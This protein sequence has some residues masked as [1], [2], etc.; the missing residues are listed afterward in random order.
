ME[1]FITWTDPELLMPSHLLHLIFTVF[2]PSIYRIGQTRPVTIIRFIMK[3]SIEERMVALQNA[4]AA[5]GKGSMEKISQQER[6]KARLTFL[7]DLFNIADEDVKW[8]SDFIADD[9][10][11]DSFLLGDEDDDEP[12]V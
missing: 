9:E 10:E 1:L 2:V 3:D 4:K 7:R 11:D 6:K 5:L 8:D 12:W